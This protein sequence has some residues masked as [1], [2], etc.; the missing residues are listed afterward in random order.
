M[1]QKRYAR[2]TT[3]TAIA[4]LDKDLHTPSP[5]G[6]R[7]HVLVSNPGYVDESVTVCKDS[8]SPS[9]LHS[10]FSGRSAEIPPTLD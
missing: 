8:N 4:A 10:S 7:A 3:L 6:I 2:G 9:L 5:L 1:Q